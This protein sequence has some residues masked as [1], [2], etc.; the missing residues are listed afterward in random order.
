MEQSGYFNEIVFKIVISLEAM[1]LN[2]EIQLK[3]GTTAT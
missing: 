3:F 2:R 1:Y